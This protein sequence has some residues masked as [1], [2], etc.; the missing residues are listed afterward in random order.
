MSFIHCRSGLVFVLLCLCLALLL[1]LSSGQS[2]QSSA[3]AGQAATCQV[4]GTA[5]AAS[6]CSG[7]GSGTSV[8]GGFCFWCPFTD[9]VC[10]CTPLVCTFCPDGFQCTDCELLCCPDGDWSTCSDCDE[11]CQDDY[12]VC[13]GGFCCPA[14]TECCGSVENSICCNDGYSCCG[15]SENPQCCADSDVCC[16]ASEDTVCCDDDATDS[17]SCCTSSGCGSPCY[18]PFDLGTCYPPPDADS[19]PPSSTPAATTFY[20]TLRLDEPD[21]V[22]NGLTP[23]DST[24]YVSPWQ[25]IEC[26][27]NK[28][29]HVPSSWISMTT[30]EEV[31]IEWASVR[32]QNCR[33]A[34]IDGDCATQ[35]C[36]IT[37]YSSGAGLEGHGTAQ[38][39][40]MQSQEAL[41]QCLGKP[42][43]IPASCITSVINPC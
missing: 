18:D 16:A 43:G 28:V 35:Y 31:A 30:S 24:K 34:V 21:P 23:L 38:F 6:Q 15:T 8:D 27:P 5:V 37:D 33:Y 17:D 13:C 36:P 20:R 22:T 41:A 32:T 19:I 12:P 9:N 25:H 11:C 40:A 4:N 42:D 2:T 14:S 1:K 29:G 7:S 3:S 39:F 26:G 10:I